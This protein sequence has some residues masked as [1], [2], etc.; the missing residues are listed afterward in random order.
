MLNE[1]IGTILIVDDSPS[2]S[3]M[4]FQILTGV[5]FQ[6]R[7]AVNGENAILEV[8]KNP[9]DL[10]LL[11]ILMPGMNGFD[12]CI[13]LKANPATREIPIIFITS[14]ADTESKVKG[15]SLGGVD[16]ITKP[17]HAAELLARV[18]VHLKLR[19]L[20]QKVAEQAAALQ[21]ANQKLKRLADLDGLTQVANR[22]RFDEYLKREWQR[23][24]RERA[25]LSLILCDVD[26]F[27]QYND[28]YGHLAGDNCLKQVALA[29]ERTLKRPAD[30]VARYGGEE[31]AIILPNTE[32][33]GAVE[34]AEMTRLEVQK[35][36][37]AH[38]R[39]QSSQY[40]TISIGVSSQIPDPINTPQSLVA[41][42]D[43][44]LYKAKKNGRNRCCVQTLA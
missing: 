34:L 38:V 12:T 23:L 37:I 9:P 33:A 19:C 7:V 36:R 8:T 18:N 21:Q 6:V 13:K 20:T 42:A 10:I 17:F 11:D 15:L 44:A 43:R 29:I 5:G 25:P 41:A 31:F 14:F 35:L 27:K 30:L 24:R 28:R 39:S 32:L 1:K 4:L 40:V 26:Y 3:E 16:Y 22:R 2:N